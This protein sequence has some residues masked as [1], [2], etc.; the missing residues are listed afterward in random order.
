MMQRL[1][2]IRCK[3]VLH[4]T[5]CSRCAEPYVPAFDYSDL[6]GSA[7]RPR[8]SACPCGLIPDTTPSLPLSDLPTLCALSPRP[9]SEDL[10]VPRQSLGQL[11][12]RLS[13]HTT[14]MPFEECAAVLSDSTGPCGDVHATQEYAVLCTLVA[15][16]GAG[17][18]DGSRDQF[19]QILTP[20]VSLDDLAQI[21]EYPNVQNDCTRQ[22][23]DDSQASRAVACANRTCELTSPVTTVRSTCPLVDTNPCPT[24]LNVVTFACARD[25]GILTY[26]HEGCASSMAATVCSLGESQFCDGP[27]DRRINAS[28]TPLR[29]CST[30]CMRKNCQVAGIGEDGKP[31]WFQC[32]ETEPIYRLERGVC[33]S[34]QCGGQGTV[35]LQYLPCI[36]NGDDIGCLAYPNPENSTVLCKSDPCPCEGNACSPDPGTTY[37]TFDAQHLEC[38]SDTLDA[39]G[40]CCTSPNRDACG[41]CADLSYPDTGRCESELMSRGNAARDLSVTSLC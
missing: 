1:L 37:P 31:C 20:F 27:L 16:V 33:S 30:P 5:R 19:D 26:D 39:M 23:F 28:C 2:S 35:T 15:D 40:N 32:P 21:D 3:S 6:I 10:C 41:L 9:V 36:N 22:A 4:S 8:V 11:T 17:T 12:A 29:P 34:P 25:E 24:T 7:T 14:Q 38:A 13:W 18:E